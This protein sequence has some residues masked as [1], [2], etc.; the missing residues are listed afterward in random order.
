MCTSLA[1]ISWGPSKSCFFTA[2]CF[3]WSVKKHYVAKIHKEFERGFC[4]KIIV[5]MIPMNLVTNSLLSLVCPF[6]EI[7]NKNQI[8]SSWWSG[9]EKYFCA[10]FMASRALIQRY[11]EFNRLLWK[12][13]LKCYSRL[14]YSSMV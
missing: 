1:R 6:V 5:T 14:Y 7:K 13:F 11:A 12:D 9:N 2:L 3:K 4:T 10:L 8:S